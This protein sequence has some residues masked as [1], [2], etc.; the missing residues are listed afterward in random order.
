MTLLLGTCKCQ[1]TISV[2]LRILQNPVRRTNTQLDFSPHP[3][4]A[5]SPN[6]PAIQLYTHGGSNNCHSW[7]SYLCHCRCAVHS[8]YYTEQESLGCN[9]PHSGL[10]IYQRTHV[11]PH[12]ESALHF[13][14]WERRNKLFCRRVFEPV[15]HGNA[16]CCG[17]V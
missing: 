1:F 9:Q 11:Q 16:D 13:R 5:N 10:T 14:R 6:I 8:A 4:W 15:R 17:Y 2:C 12:T 3:G 7:T